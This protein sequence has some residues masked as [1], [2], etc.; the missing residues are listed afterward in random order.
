M[1]V[2]AEDAAKANITS[3]TAAK[4]ELKKQLKAIVADKNAQVGIAVI[5]DGHETVTL[6]NGRRYPMMS[7][8]KFHQ[9][10]AVADYCQ[11]KGISFD[12]PVYIAKSDLKPDTYSPLRDKYPDGNIFVTIGELLEYTLHLSDNNACDILFGMTGG[13]QATDAYIRNLGIRRFA[14]KATEDEMHQDLRV[15]YTNWSTP[16][17]TARL[18]EMLVTRRLFDK[19]YQDFIIRAMVTC[20]TG[21]DR[22]SA[23]LTATNAVI[24]HKTGTG[25][26]NDE[27]RLI[28]TN[29]AGFVRLPNGKRYTIAVFVKDSAE[30][31]EATSKIIADISQ[32]VFQ[33]A[34][35]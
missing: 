35:K 21:L 19:E 34:C 18:I 23:P 33:Y 8:Y 24:G 2:R 32:A 1:P 28:G 12:T 7:V 9:A 10:L 15:C 4:S 25:D 17:E 11:R 31:A 22:L 29:D 13:P 30:S 14:I 20:Q 16:L 3:E 5:F 6:N 27:G 26:R